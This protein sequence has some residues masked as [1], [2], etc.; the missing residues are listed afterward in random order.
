MN[1]RT[2][3]GGCLVLLAVLAGQLEVLE[4]QLG[5]ID[6]QLRTWHRENRRGRGRTTSLC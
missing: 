6:K 2:A 4:I 1:G 3:L 5:R